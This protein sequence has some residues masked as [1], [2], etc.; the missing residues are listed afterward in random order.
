MFSCSSIF[1]KSAGSGRSLKSS[2]KVPQLSSSFW[3][4]ARV[5]GPS[6]P[7]CPG[8]CMGEPSPRAIK[9]KP[10]SR[11]S[12]SHHV[13]VPGSSP[14]PCQPDG[15]SHCLKTDYHRHSEANG[16]WLSAH[17][18]RVYLFKRKYVVWPAGAPFSKLS[19]SCPRLG[20]VIVRLV[21]SWV[22]SRGRFGVPSCRGWPYISLNSHVQ[23]RLTE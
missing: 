11:G 8:G 17:D 23:F 20:S 19:G 2:F 9:E 16:A 4:S 13:K 10:R 3:W 5:S 6:R 21:L 22:A 14:L 18:A 1:S 12:S 15:P 7:V